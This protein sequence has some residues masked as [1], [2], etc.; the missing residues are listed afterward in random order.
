MNGKGLGLIHE[1]RPEDH[2]FLARFTTPRAVRR[3]TTSPPMFA[4]PLDQGDTGTCV[5]HAAK[6]LLIT[7][8]R[9]IGTPKS[10]PSAMDIYAEAVKHDRWPE[11]DGPDWDFGTSIDAAGK[12]LRA[13]GVITG[14]RHIFD[15]DEMV[16][17]IGGVDENGNKVGKPV[18]VGVP[19]PRNWFRTDDKGFLPRPEGNAGG[20][21]V[22]LPRWDEKRGG[23]PFPNSW[24]TR[25]FGAIHPRFGDR[26]G[27]AFA[28]AE[29]VRH[30]FVSQWGHA[31]V[32]DEPAKV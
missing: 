5:G 20:H 30:M 10:K 19:W 13:M 12:A 28:P 8:P 17:F 16:D 31:V 25:S 14:W 1:V 3:I 32:L 4:R 15:F 23:F 26:T 2:E 24:G 9:I 29:Y 27:W 21:A 18:I 22:C 7:G 6:H 11:N